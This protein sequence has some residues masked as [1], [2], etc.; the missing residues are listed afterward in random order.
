M[1]QVFSPQFDVLS[2]TRD[3]VGESP[4]WHEAEQA[5]Y[6]VCLLSPSAAAGEY[7]GV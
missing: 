3:R 7:R 6:W 2:T 4:V 5:L 1:S